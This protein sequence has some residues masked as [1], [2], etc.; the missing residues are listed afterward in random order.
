M[1]ARWRLVEWCA[2][3]L[4]DRWRFFKMR[5]SAKRAHFAVFTAHVLG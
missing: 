5:A 4:R 2:V 3:E 1:R